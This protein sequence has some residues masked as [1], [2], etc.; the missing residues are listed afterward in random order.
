M[1][2][3]KLNATLLAL[4]LVSSFSTMAQT[5]VQEVWVINTFT[6]NEGAKAETVANLQLELV[7]KVK[8]NWDG[9]ISQQ[10]LISH[11]QKSVSTIEV[12]KNFDSLKA[13]AAHDG[14]VEYRHKI[15]QHAKMNPVVYKLAGSTAAGK[16]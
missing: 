15:Q 1:L 4:G 13:I 5:P 14:L 3:H 16:K 11:D 9:F 6:I 12:Y 2:K 10:T 7:E 8:K